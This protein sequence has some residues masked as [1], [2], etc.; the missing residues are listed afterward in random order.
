MGPTFQ[1]CTKNASIYSILCVFIL[2]SV[3]FSSKNVLVHVSPN[4]ETEQEGADAREMGPEPVQLTSL[5]WKT[6]AT[7]LQGG[8]DLLDLT[9]LES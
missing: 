6:I 1:S 9:S 5:R 2:Q 8:R 7:P 3:R 4:P